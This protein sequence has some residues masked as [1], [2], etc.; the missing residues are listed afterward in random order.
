MPS[1]LLRLFAA[2][3]SGSVLVFA[4]PGWSLEACVW[5]WLYPLLAALWL[6]QPQ[7]VPALTG[8]GLRRVWQR[9][10]PVRGP[11]GLGYLAGLCF[12]VPNLFWLRHSSRVVMGMAEDDRWLGWQVESLGLAAVAGMTLFLSLYFAVWAAFAAL[13][14]RPRRVVLQQG[15]WIEASLESLRSAFLAAAAWVVCEWLR[16]II[17]TGMG[18]NGLGVGLWRNAV[19]IQA[20]DLVGVAGLSF[21]LVFLCCVVFNTAHRMVLQKQMGRP[22][23]YHFDVLVA[24]MLLAAQMAYGIRMVKP[25]VPV[26]TVPLRVA[27]VQLNISQAARWTST[28]QDTFDIYQRYEELTRL[29]GEA[30]D[31]SGHSPVDLV[32]WPES[33]LGFPWAAR[34][35][36]DYFNDLLKLGDFSL[37]SGADSLEVA[38]PSHTSAVLMRRGIDSAQ[39]HH[40]VHLVPFGEYLPLREELPFMQTL[41]GGVL[42]G[43]FRPGDKTEPLQIDDSAVQIIPLICF[44]DTVGRLARAFVR[45]APQVMVNITNDGW[46]L[47]SAESEQHMVNALFR[48]I[49]LR[50]PLCRC[51]NTGVTCFIDER[52]TIL[53]RLADPETGNTFIEGVLPGTVQVA[54]HPP[55]TLYARWG[56]WFAVVMLVVC[57]LAGVRRAR[58]GR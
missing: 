22:L 32:V 29:Y 44:E 7:E 47:H 45:D 14:A 56:D 24:V 25:G 37:L 21:T 1:R 31:G 40:K 10:R 43:D 34:G 51:A 41:L 13:V 20:A 26:E 12:F 6:G 49:E 53:A 39:L 46:F 8:N 57:G 55:M 2:I 3:H 27:M 33:A 54:K 9:T 38:G 15:S 11:F 5:L 17:F 35:H 4:Y 23:R 19:L 16:G 48:A 52:G 36:T 50:R 30:R 28:D 18:W 58:G 42:P